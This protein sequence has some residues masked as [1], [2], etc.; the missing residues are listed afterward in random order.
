M[1]C[2]ADDVGA[3]SLNEITIY[4]NSP[5]VFTAAYIIDSEE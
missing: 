3:Y 5:A 2:Y 1:K 4:W